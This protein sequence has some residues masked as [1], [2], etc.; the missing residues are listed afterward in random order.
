[1][2]VPAPV[3]RRLGVPRVEVGVP[4]IG[5]PGDD[6]R[7]PG[8]DLLVAARAAVGLA[9]RGAGQ[10]PHHPVAVRRLLD[11]LGATGRLP[12]PEAGSRPGG[13]DRG[14]R[15]A[16][17]VVAEA[18]AGLAAEVAGGDQVL[19]QRRR[20]EAGLAEL[21]VELRSMASET[22]SPTTSSSSNGPIG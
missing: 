11:L 19:E 13:G 16:A 22:S 3:G 14:K 7:R 4:G 15:S 9:G 12:R 5:R 20:R 17:R 6:V 10:R 18:A 8:P 21:D 2:P 1:M